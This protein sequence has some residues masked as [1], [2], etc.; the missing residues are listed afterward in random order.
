MIS[1]LLQRARAGNVRPQLQVIVYI[2]VGNFR[3]SGNKMRPS[4]V[5]LG[6]S[7]VQQQVRELARLSGNADLA[8]GPLAFVAEPVA[9]HVQQ[10]GAVVKEGIFRMLPSDQQPTNK[11]IHHKLRCPRQQAAHQPRDR[12]GG[13]QELGEK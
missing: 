11:G 3:R 5:P 6:Q 8:L 4:R 12:A 10:N 7:L 1:D 13:R 2:G 9:F